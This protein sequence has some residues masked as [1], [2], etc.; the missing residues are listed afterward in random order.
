MQVCELDGWGP[1][2]QPER[3]ARDHLDCGPP[4]SMAGMQA[5]AQGRARAQG[6][7][8]EIVRDR[9]IDIDIDIYRSRWQACRLLRKD[10]R[11]LK[12]LNTYVSITIY[13]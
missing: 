3:D 9:Y 2:W 11:E 10:V 13:M 12:V 7:Y 1:R 4:K 8:I 5:A 6:N